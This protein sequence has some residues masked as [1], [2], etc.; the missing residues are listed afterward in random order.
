MC[1]R[2]VRTAHLA[3]VA[4]SIMTGMQDSMNIEENA[5]DAAVGLI[6][7]AALLAGLSYWAAT[8]IMEPS[9][10]LIIWKGTGVGLLALWAAMQ[11]RNIDGWLIALVMAC[12]AAG[13]VLLDA[14]GLN[15]GA[16]A[17]LVGHLVAIVLYLRN[18]RESLTFSQRLFVTILVPAVVAIAWFLPA[19]RSAA[20]GIAFYSLALAA[21]A[22]TAWTSRFPR[23]RTGIGAVLFV[24]SD[25]L[26]F[27]RLGPMSGSVIPGL[28]IWPLYF[29]GQAMI[30][31][32]VV[33]ALAKNAK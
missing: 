33:R 14:V 27:A 18:R 31:M 9:G 22:A 10:L 5:P 21:M 24:I 3:I 13:D 28:L 29:T 2:L 1:Y 6:L 20:P 26:I 19:D 12:G 17:F 30:V 8:Q 16:A 25:L 7:L 11:A 32:G 23:Y 15:A 4:N